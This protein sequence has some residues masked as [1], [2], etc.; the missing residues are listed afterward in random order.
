VAGERP[1]VGPEYESI[2]RNMTARLPGR[3]GTLDALESAGLSTV[4]L[5]L[6]DDYWSKYAA[7]VR[8]LTPQQLGAASS[9]FIKPDEVVWMV[10]GDLRKIE[11]GVRSLGWGEVT[12]V[13]ADGKP[14]R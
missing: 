4:N 14:L 11:A 10:I 12:V 7:N 8:A 1:L 9:K 13:D 2:M 6:A 5:G 3:F